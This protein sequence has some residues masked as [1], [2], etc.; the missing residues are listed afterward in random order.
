MA[1]YMKYNTHRREE[2]EDTE[3]GKL[4]LVVISDTHGFE[5]SMSPLPEGDV[6]IHLGD[7]AMDGTQKS[8]SLIRF[9]DWLARQSHPIKLVVRGNHDPTTWYPMA[10]GATFINKPSTLTVG[11][12]VFAFVPFFEGRENFQSINASAM[13]CHV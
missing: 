5:E 3:P 4:R 1:H 8:E 11:D 7:F 2:I 12:F 13:R 9:D 6:L 10:S